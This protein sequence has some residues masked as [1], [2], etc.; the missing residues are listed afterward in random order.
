[1]C[2]VKKHYVVRDTKLPFEYRTSEYW[3]SQSS[4]FRCSINEY[5]SDCQSLSLLWEVRRWKPR[6]I[7]SLPS[8]MFYGWYFNR[9]L[10]MYAT[11]NV[12]P[13]IVTMVRLLLLLALFEIMS[14]GQEIV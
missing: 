1:M 7:K 4:L 6:L 11:E 8:L 14:C 2:S 3:T 9:T 12:P 5:Y 10:S 13:K